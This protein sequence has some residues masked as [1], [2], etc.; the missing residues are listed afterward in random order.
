MNAILNYTP[1]LTEASYLHATVEMP[2]TL[3][4]ISALPFVPV[5]TTTGTIIKPNLDEQRRN[6]V[7]SSPFRTPINARISDSS[8]VAFTTASYNDAESILGVEAIN[9][10]GL[11]SVSASQHML[12]KATITAER[13]AVKILEGFANEFLNQANYGTPSKSD[14]TDWTTSTTNL[15]QQITDAVTTVKRNSGG[16]PDTI[17]VTEDVHAIIRNNV[18]VLDALAGFGASTSQSG[19][20]G[21]FYLPL[22]NFARVFGVQNYFVLDTYYNG[23]GLRATASIVPIESKKMLIACMGKNLSLNGSRI[24]NYSGLGVIPYLDVTP[25]SSAEFRI[26]NG[27]NTLPFPIVTRASFNPDVAGGGDHKIISEAIAGFKI[28]E[29][30]YAYLFHGAIA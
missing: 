20:M 3:Q 19:E 13:V 15:V 9:V 7:A 21:N 14:P 16:I 22:N 4:M 26:G 8:P 11:T 25:L 2:Y 5:T 1:I 18:N 17:I 28:I 30:L 24:E 29:P 23:A 6:D 12:D 27:S 10:G